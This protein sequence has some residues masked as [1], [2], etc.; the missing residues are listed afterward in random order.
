MRISSNKV[1]DIVRF[2][3]QELAENYVKGEV[4]TLIYALIEKFCHIGMVKALAEPEL[5]VS[6]SELLR[7]YFG[8]KDL[9]NNVPLQYVLGECDFLN[10]NILLSHKVLIPRPETEE[11]VQRVIDENKAK[12]GLEIADLCCG[13]GCVAVALAKNLHDSSVV[14]IDIDPEAIDQTKENAEHNAV[15]VETLKAD[16][17]NDVCIDRRFDIIFSNPPYVR[18]SERSLMR[19]NVIEHEPW[20]ALFVS[21]ENPLVFYR[22]IALFAQKYLKKDGVLYLETNEALCKETELIFT[23]LG[24][25]TK[26]LKDFRGKERGLIA[27]KKG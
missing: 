3:H 16:I 24:Y 19:A 10:T 25:Q 12:S 27:T 6:E 26:K 14:A 8:I 2:A 7:V 1:K 4:N 18:E 23:E 9:K 21:D 22:S 17:L 20:Q 15:A 11:L 5:T 13:S